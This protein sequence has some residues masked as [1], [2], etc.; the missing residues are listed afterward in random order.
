MA[1]PT[2]KYAVRERNEETTSTSED[3]SY[4]TLYVVLNG[5]R[6]C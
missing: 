4:N 3:P 2:F 1:L 5:F 6:W